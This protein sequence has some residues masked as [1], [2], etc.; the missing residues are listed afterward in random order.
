MLSYREAPFTDSIGKLDLFLR[1]QDQAIGLI[2]PIA[3]TPAP[4]TS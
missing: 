4:V 3:D 1:E 2:Y